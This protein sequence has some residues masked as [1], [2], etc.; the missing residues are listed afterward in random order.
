MIFKSCV[1]LYYN[2][3][4]KRKKVIHKQVKKKDQLIQEIKVI[5]EIFKNSNKVSFNKYF[6]K[7]PGNISVHNKKIIDNWIIRFIII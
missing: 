2:Y 1:Q 4:L 6:Q 7:Y 5:F 3:W